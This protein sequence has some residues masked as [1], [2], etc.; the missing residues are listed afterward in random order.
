MIEPFRKNYHKLVEFSQLHKHFQSYFKVVPA[1]VP[2]LVQEAQMIRHDVYCCELGWEP[3]QRDGLEKDPYDQQ[4]LHCLL[5]GIRN[6]R[7]VGCVR[8]VRSSAGCT[9]D[10]LPFQMACGDKLIPGH[11]DPE[12]VARGE[13][14]EVSRLAIVAD[15]RRRK[16]E[17]GHPVII[18]DSDFG[19]HKRRKF[20]YIPVGLYIGM[21][22]VASF[23][24]IKTLYFLTEPLL[25]VHFGRLGG[26]LTPVG[27]SIMHRGERKPYVMNVQEVLK[28]ANIILRPLIWSIGRDVKAQLKNG[29][30]K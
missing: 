3:V 9:L 11:P 10:K 14:A 27:D 29:S 13:V 21:L 24:G 20:P 15:C 17:Q 7:F 25:A 19:F 2:E 6:N 18:S 8:L 1:L 16:N 12:A 26:K 22:H 23:Y 4:S 28:G 5:K 30:K